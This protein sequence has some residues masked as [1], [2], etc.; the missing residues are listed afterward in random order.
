MEFIKLTY[1]YIELKY[2]YIPTSVIKNIALIH[3]CFKKLI[4]YKKVRG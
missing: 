2:I 1:V 4:D 3:V